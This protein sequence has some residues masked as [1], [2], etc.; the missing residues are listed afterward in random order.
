MCQWIIMCDSML[1]HYQRHMTKLANVI[2]DKRPFCRQYRMLCFTNLLIRNLYHLA[3][4][5]DRM[6]LQL[7][8]TDIEDSHFK[9][10]VSYRHLTFMVE[11][12]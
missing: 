11:T 2:P 4:D 3:T 6:S 9:Y 8:D 7:L 5:F 12:F 1:G 10:K